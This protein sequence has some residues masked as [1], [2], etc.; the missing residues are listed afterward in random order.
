MNS[1]A[2]TIISG[3][4]SHSLNRS[5]GF[6]ACSSARENDLGIRISQGQLLSYFIRRGKED[7]SAF[8]H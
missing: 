2:G 6:N 7:L 1:P 3:Q 8:R 5:L 4:L